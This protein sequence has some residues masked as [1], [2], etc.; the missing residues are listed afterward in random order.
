M[1]E[2]LSACSKASINIIPVRSNAS[3]NIIPLTDPDYYPIQ[4]KSDTIFNE[5]FFEI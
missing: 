3:I 2:P 1:E 4:Y 5:R